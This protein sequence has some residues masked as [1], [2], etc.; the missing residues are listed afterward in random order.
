MYHGVRAGR[1]YSGKPGVLKFEGAYHGWSDQVYASVTPALK[2]AG[3]AARPRA[4]GGSAGRFPEALEHMYIAP[5]NDLEAT[6]AI[7]RENRDEIGVIIVEPVMRF[8]YPE[9]GFLEGIRALCNE[10]GAVLLFDEIFSCFKA[11]LGCAQALFGV[12]PDITIVGKALANGFPL[13]CAVGKKEIM[14]L[15]APEGPV[16]F[17]GTF[18]GAL[19][20]IRA[21]QE[22]LRVMEEEKVPDVVNERGEEFARYLRDGIRRLGVPACVVHFR[23][24]I[25]MIFTPEAPRSYR[26]VIYFVEPGPKELTNSYFHFMLANGVYIQPYYLVKMNLNYAHTRADLERTADLTLEWL[27]RN[28]AEVEGAAKAAVEASRVRS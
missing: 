14:S 20:S 24:V 13:S 23:S 16:F 8:I 18:N 12:T 7:A 17:S 9:P 1:A 5:W 26:D 28:A 11:G 2:E 15:C 19:V 22:T 27:K 3:P 21:G 6:R 10:I 25:H 4:T